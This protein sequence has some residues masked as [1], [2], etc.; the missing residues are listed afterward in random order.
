MQSWNSEAKQ[1]QRFRQP[2][3]R[4]GGRLVDEAAGE[5]GSDAGVATTAGT[6]GGLPEV[7]VQV[8]PEGS[9]DFVP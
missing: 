3:L 2:L 9:P 8:L 4:A 5:A 1:S 6:A 7:L